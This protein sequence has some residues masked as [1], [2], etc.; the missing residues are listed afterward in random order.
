MTLFEVMAT[1]ALSASLMASTMVVLRSSHAAWK[2]HGEELEPAFSQNAVQRYVT[3]HTRQANSVTAI[4][5][6]TDTSGTLTI[7]KSDGTTYKWDYDS[8]SVICSINGASAE[9]IADNISTLAFIGYDS[10]QTPTT[11]PNEIRSVACQVGIIQP[12]G[13]S[14]TTSSYSWLRSW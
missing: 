12:T 14:R 2:S 5:I 4:S 7:L 10:S 6:A 8:G 9:P 3:Q 11:D 1:L 13:G